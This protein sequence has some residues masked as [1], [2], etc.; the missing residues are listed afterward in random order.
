MALPERLT[1]SGGREVNKDT[2]NNTPGFIN[3]TQ[4]ICFESDE[5]GGEEGFTGVARNKRRS[6]L[7]VTSNSYAP[8]G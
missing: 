2:K 8:K 6:L 7:P 3:K 5:F 1:F 4:I